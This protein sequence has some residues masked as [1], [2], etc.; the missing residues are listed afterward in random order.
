L[1]LLEWYNLIIS[2][3][4][5]IDI[6]EFLYLINELDDSRLEA[7]LQDYKKSHRFCLLL[8]N[9]NN[10]FMT[11]KNITI[12]F[13]LLTIFIFLG[14]AYWGFA[15]PFNQKKCGNQEYIIYNDI[16]NPRYMY[17]TN[18]S[19]MFWKWTS[20]GKSV[21]YSEIENGITSILHIYK[22]GN[23]NAPKLETSGTYNQELYNKW[24][25]NHINFLPTDNNLTSEDINN[26]KTCFPGSLLV[27]ESNI[28]KENGSIGGEFK[29][30]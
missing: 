9:I 17:N 29:Q 19:K 3:Y 5:Y 18:N 24:I 6:L 23:K 2:K 7:A 1:Q 4:E 25:E 11:R 27:L 30:I 8:L 13:T 26:L 14:I 10:L 16:E 28:K 15:L 22:D 21:Q 20:V 12:S